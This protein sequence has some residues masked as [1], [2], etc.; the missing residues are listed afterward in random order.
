MSTTPRTRPARPRGAAARPLRPYAGRSPRQR[1]DDRRARLVTSGLE[2]FG[3]GGYPR[4]PIE[5]IC[6]HARVT[7][8][9]F[10]EEFAGREELLRAVYDQVIDEARRA[11]LAALAGAP[12]DADAKIRAGV[13]AFVRSYLDDPR[14]VRVACVE[15]VGVSP[16]LEAHRR[17]VIHEFARMIRLLAEQFA[18]RAGKPRRDW[19]LA[20][21]AMAGGTNELLVEWA[22]GASRPPAQRVIDEVVRLYAAILASGGEPI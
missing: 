11:V 13:T 17:S 15:I 5:R 12:A 1:A 4:T 8:R 19:S 14:H 22:Y 10:Y 3:N 9:H 16:E 18:A 20:A 6:A 2:L 21:L 7:A